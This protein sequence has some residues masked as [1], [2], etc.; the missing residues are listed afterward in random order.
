M[1]GHI[2]VQML[3]TKSV[4]YYRVKEGQTVREIA[5]YFSVSPY[6]LAKN[7]GLE[8]EPPKGSILQ[9]PKESGNVYVVQEGDSKAL[10]C[11]S[12]ESYTKK[13]G[14]DIFYIGMRVIL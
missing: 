5:A 3:K 12:A 1:Q 6:L 14:T 4:K 10:L 9:I 13:N 11:G 7:N 8:S 2:L